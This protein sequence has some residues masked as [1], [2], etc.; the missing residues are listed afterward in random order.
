MIAGALT[1]KIK[2]AWRKQP[3][4]PEAWREY[5]KQI[6][7]PRVFTDESKTQIAWADPLIVNAAP[8]PGEIAV[9]CGSCSAGDG[10]RIDV[11]ELSLLSENRGLSRKSESY[12]WTG[13]GSEAE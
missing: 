5:K 10:F 8:E 1:L 11:F 2:N 4:S 3:L 6:L 9:F 13:G 7:S 12:L